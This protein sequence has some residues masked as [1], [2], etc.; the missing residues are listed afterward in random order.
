M[1]NLLTRVDKIL[2][3]KKVKWLIIINSEAIDT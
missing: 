1:G 2:R 3:I